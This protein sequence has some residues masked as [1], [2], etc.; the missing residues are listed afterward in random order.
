M[1]KD[2][3]DDI[4]DGVREISKG[5]KSSE[6]KTDE[7][8]NYCLQCLHPAMRSNIRVYSLDSDH[9]LDDTIFEAIIHGKLTLTRQMRL[10]KTRSRFNR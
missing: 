10:R 6:E 5:S 9:D 1:F 2:F 3:I 4:R 8:L 7:S